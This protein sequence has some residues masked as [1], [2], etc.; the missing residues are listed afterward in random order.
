MERRS[1]QTSRRV[2]D[3]AFHLLVGASNKLDTGGS[4]APYVIPVTSGKMIS[5]PADRFA[6]RKH[7]VYFRIRCCQRRTNVVTVFFSRENYDGFVQKCEESPENRARLSFTQY[8]EDPGPGATV[9]LQSYCP[10]HG[11]VYATLRLM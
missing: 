10:R 5:L 7:P 3:L 6:G 8:F 1:G 2:L 9:E 11:L 4:E